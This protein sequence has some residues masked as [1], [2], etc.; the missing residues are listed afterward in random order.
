MNPLNILFLDHVGV[1][2]G[3]ELS[4]LDI[5]RHYKASSSVLLFDD[6][7]FRARLEQNGVSVNVVRAPSQV[8]GASREGGLQSLLA[9]P[10]VLLMALRVARDARRFD[11]LY[12]N[13][14]KALVIAAV[15]GRLARRPVVWHLRDMLTQ[16]H[17]SRFNRRVAVT[18]ANGFVARVIVNSQ[19]TADAFVQS[20]GNA[21]L[22]R[23]VYNGFDPAPFDAVREEDIAALKAEL[24]VQDARIVSV[25]SRL[26]PWKGQHVLLEA[27]SHLPEDVHALIVGEAIFGEREYA[28][29][30][31][32]QVRALGLGA[33]VHF[34][35]FR[36]DIPTLMR[37]SDVVVHAS[38]SP[39]PFG[40]VVVEGM[41]AGKPVVATRAGGVLEIVEDAQ[42]GLLVEPGDADDLARA[43]NYLLAH[44]AEA[45]RVAEAGRRRALGTFSL[46]ALLDGVAS[47]LSELQTK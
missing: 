32:E 43:L 47:Q 33:R 44:P 18:L 26:A 34:L 37:A 29:A 35:G 11:L 15:A 10:G 31:R 24:G 22:T 8:S 28:A 27:L 40:R 5:A 12:A 16:E 13:S 41:L 21:S 4:L 19:A 25:F 30:L 46:N 45:T 20:G 38:T 3:A 6:G 1:L 23:V 42:S 36:G 39:E 14:Q 7:P 9:T 2:G 17:F